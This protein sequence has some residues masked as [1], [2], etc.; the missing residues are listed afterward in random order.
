MVLSRCQRAS[1]DVSA[2]LE[3]RAALITA[4]RV[5]WQ[6]LLSATRANEQQ[7]CPFVRVASARSFVRLLPAYRSRRQRSLSG[8][9]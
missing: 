5:R 3:H 1:L 9:V 7:R 8:R 2:H 6:A 4:A